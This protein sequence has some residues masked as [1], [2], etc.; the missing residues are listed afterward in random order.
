MA[1]AA[2]KDAYKRLN[3]E[4]KKAVDTIEGPV[5]VIAGPGT[6]KTQILT[7]RIANI[8]Q[9]T[10]VSPDSILALTF[11][12]SAVFSMRKRLVDI[13]GP[14]AYRVRIHTFHG[15]C[16]DVITRFPDAF[17]RIVGSRAVTDVE[18]ISIL[19]EIILKLPLQNIRPYG[20][21]YYYVRPAL[22]QIGELKRENFTPGSFKK[23]LQDR[24]EVF[25]Q[26]PDL[27][28]EK[29]KYKGQMK[30][31]YATQKKRMEKDRELHLVFEAYEAALQEKKLY[32][33]E[34]M[35]LETIRTLERDAELL[36]ILQEEHQYIL[37]DEHQ[38]ANMSQNRLLELLSSFH[39]SPN[40]FI[41][42]DEKQAIFR[43]QGASLANFLYFKDRY[44]TAEVITLKSNYRSAQD[45]LDSAHT[46]IGKAEGGVERV[47]LVAHGEKGKGSILLATLQSP[48]A[49]CAYI[50]SHVKN[51][52][53]EGVEPDEIAVLYRIN[54]DAEG[55]ADALERL[56][57]PVV[58]QSDQNIL[59]DTDIRRFALL[60]K[61][62]ASYGT[63]AELVPVLHLDFLEL[64]SLDVARVLSGSRE[65]G[66]YELLQNPSLLKRAHIE[67]PT[68][69]KELSTKLSSWKGALHN[70]GLLMGLEIVA[71][72]SG[73][74]G[75][76]VR[77]PQ[78]F[79]KLGSLAALFAEAENLVS[80]NRDASIADFAAHL[81]LLEEYNLSVKAPRTAK[82]RHAV[83]LLTAHRAKGLEFAHVVIA[84]VNEGVWGSRT[85]RTY[86]SPV[87]ES[88]DETQSLDDE[89][90]LFYVA[91]TR[92]KTSIL[93]TYAKV[94]E[95]GK[96]LLSSQFLEE[97]DKTL[98][99]EVSTEAFEK[100]Y[101]S[102]LQRLSVRIPA[103]LD[104]AL[105]KSLFAE[106]GLSVTA[107]N[108]YLS[109]PWKYFYVNLLRV[110]QSTDKYRE[111]GTAMHKALKEYFDLLKEGE[112]IGSE[113]LS[114]RFLRYVAQAP[115][116]LREVEELKAKGEKALISFYTTRN[117][118]WK[119]KRLVAEFK[120][121]TQLPLAH[122]DCSHLRLRGDL[123]LVEFTDTGEVVVY[124][125]KTGKRKSKNEI[126]GTDDDWGDYRRQIV[127]YKLLLDL[128]DEGK[129]KMKE[130]V[131]EFVE[132]DEKGR[133]ESVRIDVSDADASK[134]RSEIERV[135][136][137]IL[138]LS[139]ADQV[140]EGKDCPWCSMRLAIS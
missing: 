85:T 3:S 125:F 131:I 140:C 74:I 51:L 76:L 11:T 63:A 121:T 91:L 30:G 113:G 12:E 53:N 67:N 29:G 106:Q 43:F 123:D 132:P 119:G 129:H 25:T 90:R 124:D 46:L 98:L 59:A 32:D 118:A 21:P 23:L 27:Y 84:H 79:E 69:L 95:T 52:I 102:A 120:I 2:F 72:E 78:A 58:I 20:D 37:A 133:H 68:A 15:F 104:G 33:F 28:H 31:A 38:D 24:E 100:K 73:F 19:Q 127:F 111:Y 130:G 88:P 92:A 22:S 35:I 115:L 36:L 112:D 55:I 75:A 45:I 82:E 18:R 48:N 89:R 99:T 70:K 97:L 108:N 64:D 61:A 26:L 138:N 34:D 8:L 114:A 86:F 103:K 62:L 136:N 116:S 57:I 81:V 96:P 40:L 39:E 66:L 65:H 71:R 77:N 101:S 109:C 7:L 60:L 17:P 117:E 128:F 107:L 13:I 93:I 122:V 47:P 10:D 49:E 6:G 137:E 139:F 83:T 16:N 54:R 94:S 135:S 134:L 126:Y 42:G 50:A 14:L 105:V 87:F 4:Q 44:K 80:A 110:P 56:D 5:M 9:K 41:V 1:E